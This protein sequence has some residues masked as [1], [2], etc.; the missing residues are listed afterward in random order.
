MVGAALAGKTIMEGGYL[1]NSLIDT[2]TLIASDAFINRIATNS[3]TIGKITD[4]AA[5]LD[6]AIQVGGRNLL[7]NSGVTVQNS[8]Y[9]IQT[10]A[11][12]KAIPEGTQVTVTIEGVLAP[13][14]VAF[15]LYNSSGSVEITS[16]YHTDEVS[17]GVY[18]KTFNWVVGAS[19]N[20]HLRIYPH[21]YETV[22]IST[23]Y[24]IKLS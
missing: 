15:L 18:R 1:R 21:L 23:I 6:D 17:T 13:E 4:T 5:A 8:S 16:V 2:E 10:Y 3:L 22:A 24:R 20:T 14:K 11:L 19:T 7:R 9:P 12:T